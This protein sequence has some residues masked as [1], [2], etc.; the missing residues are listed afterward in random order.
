MSLSDTDDEYSATVNIQLEDP[1]DATEF[2]YAV[3]EKLTGKIV[4][5]GLNL[6]ELKEYIDKAKAKTPT[7][8]DII[9]GWRKVINN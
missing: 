4:A 6:K 3:V 5:N 9:N 7:D 2:V 8:W 1:R